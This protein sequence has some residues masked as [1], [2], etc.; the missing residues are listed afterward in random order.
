MEYQVIGKE[1]FG[2]FVSKLIGGEGEVVGVKRKENSYIFGK[3]ED[4]SELCLDYDTTVLP[5]KKLFFPQ[6]ESLLKFSRGDAFEVEPTIEAK[7][8]VIVGLHPCDLQGIKFLDMVFAKDNPDANY[9]AKR[10]NAVLIGV[11]DMPWEECFCASVGTNL[12]QE[13]TFDL[14]LTD[15]GE[16]YVV[17]IGSEKGRKLLSKGAKTKP[18]SDA[19]LGKVKRF[20]EEKVAEMRVRFN[21]EAGGLPRLM[22][23]TYDSKVWEEVAEKCFSCGTCN[24]V[25]PTCYC[26]DVMDV[27]KLS[28]AEGT[29]ER[30]WDGCMLSD[31]A[32]VAG[33]HNFRGKRHERLRH[34]I[35]RKYEY[36]MEQYG[37]SFCVGCGRCARQC[38]SDIKPAD[39]VNQL[40]ESLELR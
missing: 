22:R 39:I 23:R 21:I 36:L 9:L 12:P 6:R 13:G 8:R 27:M 35:L 1:E 33:G 10:E 38:V 34:R 3:L 19:D 32:V 17:A 4:A 2:S 29:R 7:P 14:F 11:D 5:P 16:S 15:I 25:C 20:Q 30:Q 26:F 31:F 28:L 18:A 24:L 37:K 40:L